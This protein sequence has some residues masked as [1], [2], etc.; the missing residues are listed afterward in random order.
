V[1]WFLIWPLAKL[2]ALLPISL[3]GI[4]VREVALAVLLGRVAIPAIDSVALGLLWNSLLISGSL[5]GGLLY[6][7]LKYF[8]GRDLPTIHIILQKNRKRKSIE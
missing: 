3:G 4:G 1:L 6:I 8:S 5:F 7:G 2:S